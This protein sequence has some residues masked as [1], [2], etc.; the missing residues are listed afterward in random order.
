[1]NEESIN[2]HTPVLVDE[3]LKNINLKEGSVVV[4]ATLGGGGHTEAIL[5]KL[6]PYDLQLPTRVIGIDQDQEAI[7]EAKKNLKNYKNITFVKENFINIDK[8]LKKLKIK[9]VDGILLDLGVSSH[10]LDDKSRG[11]SFSEDEENLNM[12]LDMRM[13]KEN[14]LKANEVLNSYSKERLVQILYEYGEERNSRKIA[15]AIVK[16]RKVKSIETVADL[17]EIVRSVTHPKKI[18]GRRKHFATNVFRALRMEVNNELQLIKDVIPK[19]IK[20]LKP[21]GR[22]LII[23]FHSLEDRIVKHDFRSLAGVSNPKISLVTK[24]PIIASS[25]EQRENPRSRSAKLRVIQKI[26]LHENIRPLGET[27]P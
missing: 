13:D 6:K 11:F 12:P 23:T 19:A 5:K 1:M 7:S 4:D 14:G 25:D 3:I 20:A 18:Y 9:K 21:N 2:F 24:K 26:P 8:I 17:I 15:D 16:Y 22:L 10:Q 27:S